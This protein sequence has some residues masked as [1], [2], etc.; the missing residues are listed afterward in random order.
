MWG[1]KVFCKC[2]FSEPAWARNLLKPPILPFWLSPPR[3]PSLNR[4][5]WEIRPPATW[6]LCRPSYRTHPT[7]WSTVPSTREGPSRGQDEAPRDRRLPRD[8]HGCR[9]N[10]VQKKVKRETHMDYVFSELTVPSLHGGVGLDL[11]VDVLGP[12]RDLIRFL[13][14]GQWTSLDQFGPGKTWDR[15]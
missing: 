10:S 13:P 2:V 6:P 8:A 14:W 4:A 11:M 15:L 3:C 12:K 9:S 7:A 5:L 1:P